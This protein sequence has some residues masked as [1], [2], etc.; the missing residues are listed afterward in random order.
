MTNLIAHSLTMSSR[1]IADLVE[2]RHDSVK[3]TIERLA[4]RGVIQRPPLV[5][6]RNHQNQVIEEYRIGKRDSY[7]IVAQLSPEFTARLVDLWQALE[8]HQVTHIPQ[9]LPD[10]LR[11]AADLAEHNQALESQLAAA[12]PKVAFVDRYVNANGSMTFRQVCKLLEAKEPEFRG[13]LLERRIM[14][15]LNGTL[16]P[17][18]HYI[19]TKRFEVKTGT[20]VT[21]AHAFTQTRFTTKGVRWVAGLWA[22]YKVGC[23]A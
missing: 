20:N 8:Q 10:A 6:V 4:E 19:D 11:L 14:Y 22:E 18:Q 2:S 23:L 12:A 17:Y 13:F 21:N 16:L 5:E 7:V 9:T 15:R 3:R 1:E